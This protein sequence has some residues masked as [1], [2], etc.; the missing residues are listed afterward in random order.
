MDVLQVLVN[1]FMVNP[2]SL[3]KFPY[4]EHGKA[5]VFYA[6]TVCDEHNYYDVAIDLDNIVA[7]CAQS[8]ECE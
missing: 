8:E 4:S 6:R 2:R 3:R 1:S 5:L 7:A